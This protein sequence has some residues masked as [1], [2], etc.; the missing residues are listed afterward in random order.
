M[1]KAFTVTSGKKLK[2][3]DSCTLKVIRVI[4]NWILKK[5]CAGVLNWNYSNQGKS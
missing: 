3:R 5:K 4:L 2:G 1:R